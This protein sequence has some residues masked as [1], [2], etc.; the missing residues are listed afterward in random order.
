M[1]YLICAS[2][3]YIYIYIY[4]RDNQRLRFTSGGSLPPRHALKSFNTRLAVDY[5]AYS[6]VMWS[7][8]KL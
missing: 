2:L 1:F 5:P 8:A 7:F 4:I 3:I 6:M